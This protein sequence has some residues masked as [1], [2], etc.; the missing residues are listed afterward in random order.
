[1]LHGVQYSR[2]LTCYVPSQFVGDFAAPEAG[3]QNQQ[4]AYR[5]QAAHCFK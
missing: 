2:M 3:V 1:M 4:G 5:K